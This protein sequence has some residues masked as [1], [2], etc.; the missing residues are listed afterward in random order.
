M[1]QA[2]SESDG[3]SMLLVIPPPPGSGQQN[4]IGDFS[5]QPGT[6]D[7]EQGIQF[8]P[9]EEDTDSDVTVT[10]SEEDN[11]VVITSV[12]GNATETNG[13]ESDTSEVVVVEEV[14][15]MAV[16]EVSPHAN[17][18]M[19]DFKSP[20]KVSASAAGSMASV[21]PGTSTAEEE[22]GDSE[23]CPIC[24][25]EWTTS[26]DHRLASLK[27]GHLFGHSCID[28]WLK[29]Q[30][31]KCPQCNAKAKKADIRIIYARALKAVDT[32]D[33]DRALKELELE[34]EA[35]RKAELSAAQM[36]MQYQNTIAECNRMREEIER[37]RQQLQSVRTLQ[38][39]AN[40]NIS[41]SQGQSSQNNG[42]FVL[43]KT[44]KIWEAGGCR[45]MAHCDSQGILVVSQPTA[46]PLFPGFGIKKISTF[47]LKTS[48]YVA[49]HNKA[50]RDV[51]FKP[52]SRDSLLL[53]CSVDKTVKMTS[54]ISNTVVQT[55]TSPA[56]FWSCVWSQDPYYFFA[57]KQN[58][59]VVMFDI[60]KSTEQLENFNL[61][62]S[63][64]PVVSLQYV[65]TDSN[66]SFSLGGLLVGQLDKTF[67]YEKR[68]GT[69]FK[70]HVMP[71]EG[72]LTCLTF[73]PCTRHVLV[74]LRPTSKHPSVR[75]QMYELTTTN[76][77][78]DP[79]QID[80]VCSGNLVQTFH[81][82]NTMKMLARGRLFPHPG[83]KGK[84]LACVGDEGTVSAQVWDA[85]T[86]LVTQKLPS[87]GPVLDVCT[88]MANGQQYLATLTE[89]LIKVH[90]WS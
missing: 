71:V 53:S 86:G 15:D 88:F 76:I 28:K 22:D 48:Q 68:E 50:I 39:Q 78:Q 25:E 54:L 66:S 19:T 69:D 81:G 51:S 59:S 52:Q 41:S 55:Y 60:R 23:C 5:L 9:I 24:L 82:G 61:N 33:R 80:N 57:G 77:S 58:G 26:G 37:Q 21:N 31:G 40:H 87:T 18:S 75:H 38:P 17:T 11:E 45:V 70:L 62:G 14:E 63:R 3:Q 46:S 84:L 89:K 29:G 79:S 85:G 72:S 4:D 73:E 36:K 8:V 65:P 27:C 83:R 74:S 16:V 56:P 32:S 43:E 6:H 10:D 20:K 90:K 64:S 49:I 30:G 35:R 42:M 67:F 44:I 47:D 34:K 2:D 12:T 13:G 7:L 1:A